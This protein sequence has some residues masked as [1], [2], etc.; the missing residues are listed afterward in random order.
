MLR[1]VVPLSLM[2]TNDSDSLLLTSAGVG[3][4]SH[5]SFRYGHWPKIRSNAVSRGYVSIS[6]LI[7][8]SLNPERLFPEGDLRFGS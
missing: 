4:D 1:I 6:R 8:F 7:S 3:L 5:A 2:A